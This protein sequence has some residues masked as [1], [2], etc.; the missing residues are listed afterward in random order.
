MSA[1]P[2]SASAVG[3]IV[4]ASLLTWSSTLPVGCRAWS[5]SGDVRGL[6][7]SPAGSLIEQPIE[8][9]PGVLLPAGELLDDVVESP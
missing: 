8:G 5:Q 6:Q 3:A 7:A 9:L 1:L 4:D 2:H